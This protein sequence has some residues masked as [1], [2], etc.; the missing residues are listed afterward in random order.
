VIWIFF[1]NKSYDQIIGP[2]G[3]T[4]ASRAAFWNQVASSCGLATNYYGMTHPSLPNYLG[5]S[6]GD[7]PF[8]SGNCLPGGCGARTE[9]S[10]Y[11][12]LVA[13]GK[14]W[15]TYAES[16][17]SNCYGTDSYPY[18]AH[19]NP[20]LYYADAADKC[21]VWNVPF[22]NSSAGFYADLAGNK[23]PDLS[24]VIPNDCNNSHDCTI[25]AA[26]SWLQ[27][28]IGKIQSSSV[29]QSGNTVVVATWDEGKGGN[30]GEDCS[31]NLGDTSCHVAT[32]VLSPYIVPGTQSGRV[33]N[34][35]S[36]LRTTEDL[37]G[38]QSYLGHAA[39]AA[40]ANFRA[41]FGL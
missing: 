15:R 12:Q 22:G 25:R 30:D 18:V 11:G 8:G 13:A 1:E 34:H 27:G 2:P 26:D 5:A 31:V 36:L 19:H 41:D 29:Y 17:P 38:L 33:L 10:I 16:M 4:A 40:T 21:S 9:S 28:V 37:L 20:A 24:V 23:L 7:T 3:S 6:S 39:D 32:L 14:T 35:Y